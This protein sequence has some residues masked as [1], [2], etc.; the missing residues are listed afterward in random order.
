MEIRR[1]EVME[2]WRFVNHDIPTIEQL[3]GSQ[4]LK[5]WHLANNGNLTKEVQQIIF[6]STVRCDW[7]GGIK[8]QGWYFDFRPWMRC[9]WVKTQY[10]GIREYWA[11][12]KQQVRNYIVGEGKILKIVE[13]KEK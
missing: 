4:T 5:L 2:P 12:S 8:Y 3:E 7:Q 9:F 13:I 1:P 10:G 6:D 11:F